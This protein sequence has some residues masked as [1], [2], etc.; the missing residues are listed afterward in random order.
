MKTLA[1]A[2]CYAEHEGRTPFIQFKRN[3]LAGYWGLPGGKFD[4]T[5][6]LPQAAT[7]EMAE[8]IEHPVSFDG[9]YGLV[10]EIVDRDDGLLRV[11]LS[12]CKVSVDGDVSLSVIDKD[13]GRIEWFTRAEVEAHAAEFVPSD[14]EM[15]RSIQNGTLQGYIESYLTVREGQL[16]I[17]ERFEPATLL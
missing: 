8:E 17:L 14:L 5:E 6:F 4:D 16:P 15:Y 12:V 7:R 11:M 1:V 13:E 9:F 2:V 10:D 3:H